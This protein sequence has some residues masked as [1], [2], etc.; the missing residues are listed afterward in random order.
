MPHCANICFHSMSTNQWSNNCGVVFTWKYKNF[1]EHQCK[2]HTSWTTKVTALQWV[3]FVM[4]TFNVVIFFVFLCFILII[5]ISSWMSCEQAELLFSCFPHIVARINVDLLPGRA[6][7]QSL[8]QQQHAHTH[9]QPKY[10]FLFS[11][12]A[13]LTQAITEF[14]F[15]NRHFVVTTHNKMDTLTKSHRF[16][17]HTNYL[18]FK[19]RKINTTRITGGFLRHKWCWWSCSPCESG[20]HVWVID[21]KRLNGKKIS[22]VQRGT[23]QLT[24]F[25]TETHFLQRDFCTLN[26]LSHGS[27]ITLNSTC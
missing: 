3:F 21:I 11:T 20:F 15:S 22:T 4:P 6:S 25:T 2:V 17:N 24:G 1:Q 7:V 14:C 12:C 8:F 5:L 13:S 10:M 9:T 16:Q 18:S 26:P 23:G 19:K 27:W